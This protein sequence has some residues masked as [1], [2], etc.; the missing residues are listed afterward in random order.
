MNWDNVIKSYQRV[1]RQR[2]ITLYTA[3]AMFTAKAEDIVLDDETAIL[4][5][6]LIEH[7]WGRRENSEVTVSLSAVTAAGA[8]ESRPF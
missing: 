2:D 7:P 5:D 8:S 6:C 4:Y 3:S 1:S